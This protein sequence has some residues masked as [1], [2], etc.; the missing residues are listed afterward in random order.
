MRITIE[1]IR[2]R[3]SGRPY[4]IQELMAAVMSRALKD[5]EIAGTGAGSAV[6]R[7]AC[8]LAQ[9][10]HAPNLSY[11]A[12]GSGA[13]NPFSEPLP[14]SSCDYSNLL[15][16]AVIPL[17]DLI[18]TVANGKLDVFF[19]GGLQV[20]KHGNLNLSLIGDPA[21][22]ILRGPGSAAL[23]FLSAAR[24]TIIFMTDHSHRSFVEKVSFVTAP[25]FLDGGESWRKAKAEGKILGGGPAL[26]VSPLAV[27]DFEEES[28][29]MRLVSVHPE[30]TVEQVQAATGFALVIP[31]EVPTTVPPTPTELRLLR[32]LDQQHILR[33]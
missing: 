22:P 12:G 24:R 32:E 19:C 15:C 3:S 7:A 31:P 18:M 14:P 6:A 13:F 4:E 16:E 9:L 25:G 10:Q 30:V 26:V 2:G 28:K 21:K 23:P 8:R 1:E 29:A 33:G 17:P 11:V 27:L 5:G 20:D